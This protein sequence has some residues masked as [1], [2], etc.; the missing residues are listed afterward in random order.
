MDDKPAPNVA[1]QYLHKAAKAYLA[2]IPGAGLV[3]DLA[4]RHLDA[5]VDQHAEQAT[6]YV[7]QAYS[8]FLR[9][10]Q[11][12]KNKHES[13]TALE[14]LALCK[15]LAEDIGALGGIDIPKGA[16][17]VVEDI[18][19]K[20]VEVKSVLHE[21]TAPIR[22]VVGGIFA[23]LHGKSKD[24]VTGRAPSQVLS[25]V[26]ITVS[27]PCTELQVGSRIHHQTQRRMRSL[28]TRKSKRIYGKRIVVYNLSNANGLQTRP[29]I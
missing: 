29:C 22:A 21:K 12:G 24:S 9:I 15:R 2:Y 4:F 23:D 13:H 20:A 3:V 17:G 16:R 5:V 26:L 1:L 6:V 27:Q 8:D 19:K 11:H 18:I 25:K 28:Q 10:V 7:K 14:V